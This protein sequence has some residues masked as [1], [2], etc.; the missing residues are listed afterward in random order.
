MS[1][2]IELGTALG[3]FPGK[4]QRRKFNNTR[5]SDPTMP[6]LVRIFAFI[7]S[8]KKSHDG[9]SP[10]F[11]EIGGACGIGSTSMM[12]FY[13]NKLVKQGLIRRPE[14]EIGKRFATRIEVIGGKWSKD[15]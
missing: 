4:T 14:P 15:E 8:Y 10:T 5:Y 11:R 7:V 3:P 13:L 12:L 6:R 2:N 1:P 9:N